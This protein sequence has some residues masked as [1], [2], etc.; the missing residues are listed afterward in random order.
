MRRIAKDRDH[1]VIVASVRSATLLSVAS[2]IA[3][4]SLR[5]VD[6]RL[7]ALIAVAVSAALVPVLV[8]RVWPALSRMTCLIQLL[9]TTQVVAAISPSLRLGAIIVALAA[10]GIFGFALAPMDRRAA[11][12][13]GAAKIQSCGQSVSDEK[14]AEALA[15]ASR[16]VEVDQLTGIW[17]R[18]S[19][20][21]ELGLRIEQGG[22]YSVLKLDVT[23]LKGL[24]EA[25]G[26]AFGDEVLVEVASRL[27]GVVEPHHGVGRMSGDKFAIIVDHAHL[28]V[29][30]VQWTEGLVRAIGAPMQLR[31]LNAVATATAGIA[32]GCDST[33]KAETLLRWAD[34]AMSAAKRQGRPMCVFDE[35][36]EQD[37][38]FDALL[39]ADLPWAISAGEIVAYFQPKVDLRSGQIIGAEALARWNH[40]QLGML[41]ASRFV[42]LIRLS[43]HSEAFTDSM[44]DQAAHAVAECRRAGLDR[45]LSVNIGVRSL[46]DP[47]FA[48]RV[49]RICRQYEIAPSTLTLELTEDEAMDAS[50]GQLLV[51]EQLSMAGFRLSIDDFGTGHS[52]LARLSELPID[53]I[54]I[55]RE[56]VRRSATSERTHV[57]LGAIVDMG[58]RLGHDVIAEGIESREQATLL[59]AMGCHGGQGYLFGQALTMSE[60]LTRLTAQTARPGVPSPL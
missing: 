28:E 32:H 36:L 22:T 11:N 42:H 13:D 8:T 26:Y 12:L 29:P 15:A 27:R 46:F 19:V 44:V 47:T 2:L 39:S 23:N 21:R 58:R 38:V 40:P 4:A 6:H 33:D 41:P 49:T 24:N 54:K 52:S 50:S 53:E 16:V 10:I 59:S 31:G 51:L 55:D 3:I 20:V 35:E 37:F 60:L 5:S 14:L 48:D 25:L 45:G 18:H 1:E 9:L 57:I 7:A 56:F 30:V 34:I 43:S 17:N